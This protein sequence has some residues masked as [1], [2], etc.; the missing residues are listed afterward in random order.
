MP[1]GWIHAEKPR[2]P[3]AISGAITD[4]ASQESVKGD[5][6]IFCVFPYTTRDTTTAARGGAPRAGAAGG[7]A[8]D[9]ER[10]ND[11]A[12][13]AAGRS[14]QPDLHR[15]CGDQPGWRDAFLVLNQETSS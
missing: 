7:E 11:T 8:S 10:D 13:D 2:S 4:D 14:V 6:L 3:Q 12:T 9:G 1:E 5:C 15:R